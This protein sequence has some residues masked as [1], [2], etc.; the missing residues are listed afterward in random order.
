MRV[1]VRRSARTRRGTSSVEARWPEVVS[2]QVRTAIMIT[3]I[4]SPPP[5]QAA[6]PTAIV[7]FSSVVV[8]LLLHVEKA[9]PVAIMS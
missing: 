5:L 3:S 9:Y 1:Q 6:E 7:P 8:K 2:M 4:P